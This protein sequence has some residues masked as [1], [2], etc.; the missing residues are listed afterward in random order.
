M[1]QP[2]NTPVE[3]E[4]DEGPTELVRLYVRVKDGDGQ[5]LKGKVVS[6][7][8]PTC[9]YTVRFLGKR[10]LLHGVVADDMAFLDNQEE[11][12]M[13]NVSREDVPIAHLV[14]KQ[15]QDRRPALVPQ[16]VTAGIVMREDVPIAQ[17]A[18]AERKKRNRNLICSQL[19][20]RAR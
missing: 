14:E 20:F 10:L 6:W 2:S 19:W 5:V 9:G 18:D 3:L 8:G 1:A 7:D 16:T 11:V 17:L 13:R 4:S 12:E 15:R